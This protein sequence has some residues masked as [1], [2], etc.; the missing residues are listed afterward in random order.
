MHRNNKASETAGLLGVPPLGI[1]PF[2]FI[3]GSSF[4]VGFNPLSFPHE[5]SIAPSE[6][7]Q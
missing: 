3:A 7:A 6:T 2:S 1:S 5:L 4:C